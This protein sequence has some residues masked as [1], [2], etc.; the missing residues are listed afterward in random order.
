MSIRRFVRYAAAVLL[1]TTSPVLAQRQQSQF[2]NIARERAMVPYED[3]MS[4]LRN[5]AF[6][7][8]I[9]SFQK[10]IDLDGSFDMAYYMLGRTHMAIRNYASAA[11]ALSKCREIHL[12]E[13]S[14]QFVN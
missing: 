10:A 5:E 2:Y 4:H 12:S 14:R 3:G 7:A 6:D 11:V 9:K 1:L 13:A 8:A